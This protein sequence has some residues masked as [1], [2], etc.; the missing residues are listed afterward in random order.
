[1]TAGLTTMMMYYFIE[2]IG[3]CIGLLPITGIPLPFVSY[4]G[5]AMIANYVAIGIILSVSV[6]RDAPGKNTKDEN[7]PPVDQL[8]I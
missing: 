8:L 7:A 3:M 4:G 5:T 2:N 1:M 6:T